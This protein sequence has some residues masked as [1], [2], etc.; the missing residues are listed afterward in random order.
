MERQGLLPY[1]QEP[2]HQT[3]SYATW[4]Q[5]KPHNLL[6]LILPSDLRLGLRQNLTFFKF[7]MEMIK[8]GNCNSK[9]NSLT[10]L[11]WE[12]AASVLLLINITQSV[13]IKTAQIR[14]N[15]NTA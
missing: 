5:S 14:E 9:N 2:S 1:S 11:H 15:S 7:I 12:G 8:L 13:T 10:I 4:I 3:L 6:I